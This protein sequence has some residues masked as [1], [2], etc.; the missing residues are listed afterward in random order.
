MSVETGARHPFD[1]V[2]VGNAGVD[3]NVYLPGDEIDWS[4]E[5]NFSDDR[6]YVGQAGGYAAR[7]Y[8]QLG[9]RTAF[10][11]SLG[12][13]WA[14]AFVRRELSSD[15]IDLRGVFPDPAGT[16][17]SVNIMYAGAAG[18]GQR[19]N[20]YD[21]KGHMGL[22]APLE[23]CRSLLAGARLAHVNIPNWGRQVL[24]VARDGS[25]TVATDL[26]DVTDPHDPY[27]RDFV[28]GSDILFF[29][30]ANHAD[31]EPLVSSLLQMKPDALLVV[32]LGAAGCAVADAHGIEY[33]PAPDLPW[34]VVD[35]N[36]AG[37]SLAVGF[38]TAYVLDGLDVAAAV[39]RGQRQARWCCTQRA[40][41]SSLRPP[42]GDGIAGLDAAGGA[43]GGPGSSAV[44]E[45]LDSGGGEGSP[46]YLTGLSVRG[47]DVLVVG[48][49]RVAERRVPRLLA[50]GARVRLVS[51]AV[52]DGL[53]GLLGESL[54]WAERDYA[55]SDVEGAWFVLAATDDPVV[56]AAVTAAAHG[57]RVFCMR[58]DSAWEGSAWTPA[59][60]EAD[61][62]T[63][64]VVGRRDPRRSVAVRDALLRVLSEN[65]ARRPADLPPGR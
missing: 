34:P 48:G 61:G 50:A 57:R 27:R 46:V 36:G 3:T 33:F 41:T 23:V 45:G 10:V 51:P 37:D 56:N 55:E 16:A 18:L 24:A 60:A 5:A 49:G 19:K 54:S 4:R 11:G 42:V 14:G 15:G 43:S 31:P 38:L 59:V 2:V 12:D 8:A 39:E 13:D 29:S 17:R 65:P 1:V 25:A 58:A 22:S 53:R 20:F 7:G 64:A 44:A 21:G 52:T 32:G 47:R 9:Y 30:A 40:S 28:L 63:V 26:Q 62:L 35:T 6:D